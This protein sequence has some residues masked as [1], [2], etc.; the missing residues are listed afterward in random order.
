MNFDDEH[1]R[2]PASNSSLAGAI[3]APKRNASR[4]WEKLCHSWTATRRDGAHE[5]REM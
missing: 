5:G 2:L 3:T 4:E 1:Q